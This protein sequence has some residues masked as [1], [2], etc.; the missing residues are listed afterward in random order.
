[1]FLII[2]TLRSKSDKLTTYEYE[3]RTVETL[4]ETTVFFQLIEHKQNVTVTTL[5]VAVMTG[6]R[7]GKY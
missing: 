1:M 7:G 6:G 2:T 5:S 3:N 4:I